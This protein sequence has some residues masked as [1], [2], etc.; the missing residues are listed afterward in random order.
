MESEKST[1]KVEIETSA[2]ESQLYGDDLRNCAIS[3][4]PEI[5]RHLKEHQVAG[6]K[7]MYDCCYGSVDSI[8]KHPGSGCILAHCM[9]LGKTL[10]LIALLHTLIRYPQLKTKKIL[11]ICPKSTIMNWADEIQTWLRAVKVKLKVLHFPDS[12]DIKKKLQILRE[13]HTFKADPEGRAGCM[14]IGYEAFRSLVFYSKKPKPEISQA[15]MERIKKYVD[16]YLLKPGAD[17]VVC[18]EGH[19]IKNRKSTTSLAVNKVSTKR[20]II[21]TGTPI[22]NNLKEYYSMVNFIKPSF[23]GTEKEF[24]NLYENPIKEGQHKDS[25]SQQIRIMKQRSYVLHKKLSKFVQRREAAL[26]KTF[27]PEKYEYVLFIPMT[28]LQNRL[29][30][31]FLDNNPLKEKFGGKS[32]IPDYTFLRKIWTHPKVLE[33]AWKNAIALRD[34]KAANKKR[35]MESED[36]PD[37]VLD[38]QVGK[39]SVENDWWRQFIEPIDLQ[40]LLPSNKLRIVLIFSAFVAVLDVVEYFMQQIHHNFPFDNKN[41]FGLDNFRGPWE[42][43]VDYYRLDGKTSK[44]IRHAMIQNFNNPNNRVKCFLISAKAGGQGIN[45]VGANRV[46]LLDTSWNPSNDQQNIFR[47]FRLGQ[48]KKCYIYRLLAMGTMEEKVYSRSVTKQAMSFRVVDEQQIDRHYNLAELSEL[49]TLTIPDPAEQPT[50][51]RPADNILANLLRNFKNLVYKYHEHDSLLENN[52]AEDLNEQEKA[53]AWEAY[54]KD[55]NSET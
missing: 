55:I 52:S 3:V 53:D 25:N 47:V 35:N 27:L 29:Y 37:D 44:N 8:E 46:I 54:E 43:N 6:V 12:S 5:L 26:L 9:G 11:V 49:Y 38:N 2:Y 23:L 20:R 48:Q 16:E 39:M 17:L 10:Q 36:E 22:Q 34:K 30:Q 15:E 50:P 19:V 7:F 24:A 42:R 51:I 13:W 4:H 45:L 14:L 33:N 28:D 1:T 32:L 41:E 31:H 40:S 21:L 18:D